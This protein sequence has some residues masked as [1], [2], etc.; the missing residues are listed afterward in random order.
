MVEKK[1][2]PKSMVGAHRMTTKQVLNKAVKIPGR[3][4]RSMVAREKQ[5]RL[6]QEQRSALQAAVLLTRTERRKRDVILHRIAKKLQIDDELKLLR[7][8]DT[9]RE[10]RVLEQLKSPAT[11]KKQGRKT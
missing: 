8:L 2:K 11:P 5:W 1:A 4:Q 10:K 3:V 6:D 7:K 9:A